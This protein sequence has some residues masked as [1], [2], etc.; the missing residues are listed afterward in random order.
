MKTLVSI[1][2]IPL[3]LERIKGYTKTS[4]G[5][6]WILDQSFILESELTLKG[7]QVDEMMRLITRFS[8]LPIHGS[9]DLEEN[10]SLIEKGSVITLEALIAI[11]LDLHTIQ[12]VL[13]FVSG[14]KP[15]FPLLATLWKSLAP[16]K[17]LRQKLETIL[18]PQGT[19]QDHA[20]ENLLRIRR[21]IHAIDGQMLSL[22]QTMLSRY[23]SYLTEPLFTM[24]NGH[25]VLP[26]S[27]S[28]K[29]SVPGMIHDVSSTGLTTFIEPKALVDLSLEKQLLF[30]EE[31]EEIFIILKSLTELIKP[32]SETLR[33][34]N[35]QIANLDVIQAKAVFGNETQ[36]Y[37]AKL[38]VTPKIELLGA[39]HP[40]IDPKK[41]I[42]NDFLL[43]EKQSIVII[44]GP[45]AGGKTVA[46][47]TVG[48]FVYLHQLAIPLPTRQ[49][50]NLSYFK[51]IYAD[52]GDQQSVLENLS[53]FAGH[54]QQLVPLTDQVKP[55]DLVLID[56]LGTGTDPKEGESLARSLLIHLQAKRAFVIVS[57]HFPGLKSLA[58][59]EPRMV[60]ASLQFD[61][62]KLLPT[63][64]FILGLPGKS[65]GL[66]MAKRYGLAPQVVAHA[67]KYLADQQATQEQKTLIK[68]QE[69]LLEV[70][71]LKTNLILEKQQ[72]IELQKQI[73]NQQKEMKKRE[74]QF[75][76][77]SK[78]KQD[79]LLE[80]TLVQ[81]EQ[82]IK[83]LAN[84]QLK[85]HEAIALKQSL[86]S[87]N[88]DQDVQ[89][90]SKETLH[91]GDYVLEPSTGISG[92]IESINGQQVVVITRDGLTLK[93]KA[94]QL[95]KTDAPTSAKQ[96]IPNRYMVSGKVPSSLNIIGM[97]YEEAKI[98]VEK[99]YDT[100]LLA[101][102]KT[103]KI[104]HG[105]GSG[106]LR[107]M[108]L[109]YFQKLPTVKSVQQGEGEQAGYGVTIIHLK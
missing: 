103:L 56:E 2:E 78:A 87:S 1:L 25:Y 45:N 49:P 3:I 39:R 101:N 16:C 95:R 22:I 67:E 32:E 13:D 104:I 55:N 37:I 66:I 85:L 34:N 26:V 72:L 33:K 76:D 105:F 31:Q 51:H 84:P 57:S 94:R 8:A 36:G 108:V 65:Y 90:D 42:A 69:E 27:T 10:L 60:N 17:P 41:V 40:L 47:K 5:Q 48:L 89:P 86:S 15:E 50:A 46:M 63:Y 74:A 58:L 53:T 59:Q 82:T 97:R 88:L 24:K 107:K 14:I 12:R 80:A 91:A 7:N 70:E 106:I 29:G 75:Q 64:R 68:L 20:S 71:K 52:I 99:Y 102:A 62:D 73:L 98:A 61:E 96:S 19:I 79:A 54:I 100:G 43:T 4:L 35:L 11:Q 9:H 21:R 30:G 28:S 44:S 6:Q 83:A 81:V 92:K 109:D 38:S 18:T 23:Q 77:D 93:V